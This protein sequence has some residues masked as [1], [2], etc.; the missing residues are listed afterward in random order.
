M[1]F[2]RIKQVTE[3]T[4]LSKATIYRLEAAGTF[5]KR[6]RLS[7]GAVAWHEGAIENWMKERINAA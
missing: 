7:Q 1:K 3:K 5:P 6:V 2:L 4:G